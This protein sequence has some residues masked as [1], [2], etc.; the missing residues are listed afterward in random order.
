MAVVLIAEIAGMSR[1][2][3][4]QAITQVRDQLTAAPGFVAHA[5]TPTA[6]GFRV[7]EIWESR[8]TLTQ[9]LEGTIMP[10]AQ[11]IG[12]PPFQPQILEADEAFTR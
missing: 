1:E 4:R 11:Q 3:Y 7:T 2:L 12:I 6:T 5:G 10:M 8:E 9:F